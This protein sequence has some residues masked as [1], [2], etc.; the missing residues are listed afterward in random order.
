[1]KQII[2]R[3]MFAMS[4]ASLIFLMLLVVTDVL[5]RDIFNA[6]LR[7]GT[8]LTQ[9]SMGLMAFAAIPMLTIRAGNISVE[10]FKL[11]E[12][13]FAALLQK[14]AGTL[15]AIVLYSILALQIQVFALRTARSGENLGDLALGKTWVWW[16]M[17]GFTILIILACI[18]VVID[19][20]RAH[21]RMRK[22]AR[23]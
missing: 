10:L 1:M 16:V 17:M 6:P 18:F 15:M 14:V 20:I 13:S 19:D 21:L 23:I 9:L 2:E 12:R 5:L 7:A 8:V 22:G 11:N 3:T 4:G